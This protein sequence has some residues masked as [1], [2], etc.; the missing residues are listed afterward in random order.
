MQ[1]NTIQHNTI[2]YSPT[3][4]NAVL[5]KTTPILHSIIKMRSKT[6]QMCSFTIVLQPQMPQCMAYIPTFTINYG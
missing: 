1:Y 5:Q 6:E 3:Q 4:Y 2:Q